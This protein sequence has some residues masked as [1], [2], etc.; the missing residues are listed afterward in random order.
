MIPN[1]KR[2][3]RFS[4]GTFLPRIPMVNPT[5]QGVL[6]ARFAPAIALWAPLNLFDGLTAHFLATHAD[7]VERI[8]VL[9]REQLIKFRVYGPGKARPD[10][11]NMCV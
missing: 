10:S 2:A 7:A 9:S 11:E 3:F 5:S 8:C 6:L 4:L 1:T